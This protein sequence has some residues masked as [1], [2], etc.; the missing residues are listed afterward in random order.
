MDDNGGWIM[1]N[2]G[3]PGHPGT[4]CVPQQEARHELPAPAPTLPNESHPEAL[5]R[6]HHR[7][8]EWQGGHWVLRGPWIWKF[9][10]SVV[11][12]VACS[13]LYDR[14]RSGCS[15]GKSRTQCHIAQHFT[16]HSHRIVSNILQLSNLNRHA[17][18]QGSMTRELSDFTYPWCT[19]P[20]NLWLNRTSCNF[21]P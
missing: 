8:I 15:S 21:Q 3:V 17:V 11:C 1:L 20:F 7:D 9:Q 6:R 16:P 4:P 14:A 19:I 2:P 5:R 10:C 12:S 18:S 13:F